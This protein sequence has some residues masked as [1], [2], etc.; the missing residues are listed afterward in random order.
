MPRLHSA[1]KRVLPDAGEPASQHIS[2]WEDTGRTAAARPSLRLQFAT[3]YE[4][5]AAFGAQ[6]TSYMGTFLR[7][8]R[9]GGE[10]PVV[11]CLSIPT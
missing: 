9:Y 11:R 2:P 3:S 4:L 7:R 6:L 8:L 10:M 5:A 1:G